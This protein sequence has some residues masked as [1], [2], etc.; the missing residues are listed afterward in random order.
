MP[1]EDNTAVTLVL[2]QNFSGKA[3]AASSFMTF[4]HP[5]TGEPC[6][7]LCDGETTYELTAVGS[8]SLLDSRPH[9]KAS[10]DA[11]SLLFAKTNHIIS[12]ALIFTVTPFNPIFLILPT[13]YGN[14]RQY[15][16][17]D[18]L[19]DILESRMAK[20]TMPIP[21][22]VISNALA[23]SGADYCDMMNGDMYKLNED[24]LVAKLDQLALVIE[25]NLPKSIE[26]NYISDM[27]ASRNAV[28][29]EIKQLARK[30]AAMDLV[31]SYLD[32]EIAETW[33]SKHDFSSLVAA[34][35]QI[36]KEKEQARIEQ[37]SLQPTGAKRS[38]SAIETKK[39]GAKAAKKANTTGNS[40][41]TS[42]FS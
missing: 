19:G 18:D 23:K 16:T 8:S 28:A 4:K 14:R 21:Q 25:Q 10:M 42:F 34:I 24:K 38:S 29:E 27:L 9:V 20:D 1:S 6:L 31:C 5:R 37:M 2:P 17:A 35:A 13:L 33:I 40:K 3:V 41:I 26:L 15:M 39:K 22:Q 36:E 7:F 30:K 12:D 11:R 32:Q